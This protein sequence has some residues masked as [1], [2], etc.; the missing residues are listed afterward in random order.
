M[1]IQPFKYK[2]EKKATE[3]KVN[4][5]SHSCHKMKMKMMR[6]FIPLSMCAN[7]L[8]ISYNHLFTTES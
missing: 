7:H 8:D 6:I 4:T 2:S 1:A 3:K 5:F